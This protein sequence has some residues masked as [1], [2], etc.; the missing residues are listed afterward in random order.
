[1]EILFMVF[2]V[3]VSIIALFA[4]LVVLRDIVKE[5][6]NAKY[7]T[8]A[9][10]NMVAEAEAIVANVAAK[11]EPAPVITVVET[12]PEQPE[13]E[14][15]EEAPAEVD[16]GK[17][18]FSAG[19]QQTLEEKYLALS[20]EARGWYDEIIRYA[21]MVEGS[22]RFKT[23]RYE[24]YKVGK[25]RLVRVLIKRGV[26][27]CEFILHNSDFKNYVS[28][29]KISVKQSA[30][31]ML[32]EDAAT[33]DAAKNSIDIVVAAIAEEKEYKKQQAREKRKAARAAAS[34]EK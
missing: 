3:V 8:G 25:N 28:E 7:H 1:M 2:M 17:I 15:V 16:D 30:T 12:A 21:S 33:V 27:N 26:I 9:R 4:V 24:E 19:Q 13:P 22:K 29:N 31:T 6:L 5:I 32:I 10:V 14:A 20:A 34:A 18:S 11:E 23:L